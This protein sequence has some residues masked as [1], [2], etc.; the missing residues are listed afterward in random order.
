[1]LRGGVQLSSLHKAHQ[2]SAVL[3][4]ALPIPRTGSHSKSFAA[5]GLMLLREQSRMKLDDSIAA[6]TPGLH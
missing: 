1:V 2:A 5:A 6:F 3:N 4:L